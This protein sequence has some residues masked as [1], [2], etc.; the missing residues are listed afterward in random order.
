MSRTV[1]IVQETGRISP[2]LP[3][4]LRAVDYLTIQLLYSFRHDLLAEV[5]RVVRAPY[6]RP[7]RDEREPKLRP[8]LLVP[9]AVVRMNER[10]DRQMPHRRAQILTDRHGV[11]SH[12]PEIT[13][14]EEDLL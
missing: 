7:A 2:S 4:R 6:K 8:D 5:D 12:R 3:S 10:N 9:A 13:Q 11:H 1:L 14:R